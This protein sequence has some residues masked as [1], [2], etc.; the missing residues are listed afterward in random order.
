MIL[1]GI[2]RFPNFLKK[3]LQQDE[4]VIEDSKYTYER[5]LKS[6]GENHPAHTH[7]D[8]II[9]ILECVKKD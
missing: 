5:F 9:F 8:D 1:Q 6:P 2:Q 7:I 3:A 4:V